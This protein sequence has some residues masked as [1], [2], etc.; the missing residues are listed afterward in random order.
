[1]FIGVTASFLH[2]VF[3][4]KNPKI[5]ELTNERAS[6]KIFWNNKEAD[7]DESFKEDK[8]SKKDYFIQKNI[9][10]KSRIAAFGE[11]AKKRSKYAKDFSFNGRS[12]LHYWLWVFGL[13]IT[14]FIVACYLANK[15]ARLKKAGLLQW[16]EPWAGILFI[17]VS[18]FWVYHTL[19]MRHMDF[20]SET[21]IV[22]L[23]VILVPFSYFLYHFIRRIVS[24]EYRLLENIRLLV[25]HV[26]RNT[27][28]D[29]EDEKW[30]V[31][32][33]VAKNGK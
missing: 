3:P 23:F 21:Y 12:S 30:N 11:I 4:S 5:T 26:L 8:L 2:R 31:L 25:S 29:K 17:S 20:E 7:L 1:M 32:E 27:R 28:E 10:E 9:N 16:Y 13:C 18:L 33:K 19:F 15:D 22:V 24:V 6:L 14:F